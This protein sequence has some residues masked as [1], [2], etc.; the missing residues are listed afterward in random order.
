MKNFRKVI[1]KKLKDAKIGD[2]ATKQ[3]AVTTALY[4]IMTAPAKQNAV[5]KD[6]F[7]TVGDLSHGLTDEELVDA[8]NE[9]TRALIQTIQHAR[10]SPTG[11]TIQ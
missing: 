5:V 6:L 9:A 8:S 11:Y 10:K 2:I 3:E 1:M 4:L 7:E